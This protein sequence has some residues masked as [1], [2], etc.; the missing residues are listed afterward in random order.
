MSGLSLNLDLSCNGES[1][2]VGM[3]KEPVRNLKHERFVKKR[4]FLERKGFLRDKQNQWSKMQGP[5]NLNRGPQ[6]WQNEK[7]HTFA[8]TLSHPESSVHKPILSKCPIPKPTSSNSTLPKPTSSNSTIPKPTSSNSTIPKP[9]SSNS[10]IPKPTSSN[11]TIPKPTS[12]NRTIPKPTSSNITIP[13]P[14]PSNSRPHLPLFKNSATTASGFFK[15]GSKSTPKRYEGSTVTLSQSFTTF[16][17]TTSSLASGSTRPQVLGAAPPFGNPLKY[18][19]LDCEMVGTGPKGQL[20]ELARC[21][22][23][24]YDGDVIYDKYIMPTRPV[25]DFRTKWSGIRRQ[26]LCNA[27]P[28]MQAK[29][30]IVKILAGKVVV[31]HAIHNDFKALT[32]SHPAGLTRDTSRIPLL[33]KK[34]GLPEKQAVSLKRLA[35]ALLNQDIQVGNKGHSSVEDAQASMELYKAVEVEW[36]RTLAF[37]SGAR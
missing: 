17:T 31:G 16:V 24:S 25:T 21:S 13:K 34:A 22:I 7:K 35:K 4:R 32:Y 23:V 20:S 36:E 6:P 19:A 27:T 8:S 15:T 14:T 10:T 12:S 33:N 28:F 3:R 1:S 37:K 26:H 9:T 18:L 30:E 2:I 11:R 5:K 29:K